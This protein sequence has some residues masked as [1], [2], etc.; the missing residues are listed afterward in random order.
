[1]ALIL[2]SLED[3]D[4]NAFFEGM[5]LWPADGLNWY[6]F[7][8]KPGM[9]YQEMM[10]I[11]EKERLGID[12][13]PGRVAHTMLYGFHERKIIGRLSVRH[14]LTEGLRKR[15]GHIGYSV[16]EPF[17][18]SGF[19]TEMV[20]QGLDYCRTLGLKSLLVTCADDNVPSWKIIEKFNGQLENRVWDETDQEMIRR[21]W[22]ALS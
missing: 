5:K 16:A 13:A 22:I 10:T 6:T 2:R 4:E 21:Y 8:W 14:D 9:T 17:R 3:T 12:L 18:K 15:G 11:L 7:A 20:R 19:A 1:M